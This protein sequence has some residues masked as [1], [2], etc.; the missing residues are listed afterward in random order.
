MKY[1]INNSLDPEYNLALEQ[2]LFDTYTDGEPLF[3]LWQNSPTVVIGR[4][5]NATE[6]VNTVY[7]LKNGINL[8]R[9]NTGGGAVYHDLGNVNFSIIYPPQDLEAMDLSQ[10]LMPV[11]SALQALGIPAE[12]TGR[13]DITV[14]GRK[15]SGCAFAQKDG[16]ILVH[17]TLLYEADTYVMQKVLNVSSEKLESKG[18]RSVRSRVANLKE[19]I[20]GSSD[21][22]MFKESILSYIRLNYC[23]C[24]KD[25]R[26][27]SPEE[28]DAVLKIK[29]ERYSDREWTYGRSPGYSVVKGRRFPFGRVNAHMDVRKGN[30]ISKLT[31]TGDFFGNK[32]IDE[33]EYLL[34]GTELTLYS[35][36]DRLKSV[37]TGQYIAGMTANMLADLLLG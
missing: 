31:F 35:L 18:V 26:E 29:N 9:R 33:L 24:N 25:G 34:T 23:D 27:L 2:Y 17:G 8:V 14:N 4:Y 3:F 15:V 20:K 13:N 32:S 5:Q 36:T 22:E 19:F 30:I 28:K 11:I 10:L 21:I 1:L 7:A 12:L 37:E 6:E 16:K